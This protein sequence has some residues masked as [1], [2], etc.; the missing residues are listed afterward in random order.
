MSQT[1]EPNLR[2]TVR[3]SMLKTLIEKGPLC[4]EDVPDETW[5]AVASLYDVEDWQPGPAHYQEYRDVRTAVM[6]ERQRIVT[7][8]QAYWTGVDK[9]YPEDILN[10][11]NAEY[12][13]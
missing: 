7:E 13:D 10:I 9:L 6:A 3:A 1:T 8:L 11:V 5:Q 12:D 2:D 4:P